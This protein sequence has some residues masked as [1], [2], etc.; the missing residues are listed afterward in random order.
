MKDTLKQFQKYTQGSGEDKKIQA[1]DQAYEHAMERV[2]GQKPG[3][4]QLAE[5]VLSWIT[6]AKR[7]LTTSELQHALAVEVGKPELDDEN[8]PQIESMVSVCVGLVTVDEESGII[9]LVHYTAQEYFKRTQKDWFPNVEES[10]TTS[11]VTYL[12]FSTF[13]GGVCSTDR[14]FEERL[15]SNQLYEYAAR[16]WGHH[17][18]QASKSSRLVIDFLESEGKVGA[19]SQALIADK[20]YFRYTYSQIFPRNMTGVHL[21]AYFGLEEAVNA[22][23]SSRRDPDLTD[24]HGRTPLSYAAENGHEAVVKLLLEKGAGVE[25]KDRYYGQTP[26]WRAAENGHEAVVELLLE[27]GADVES[28]DREFGR[29]PMLRAAEKGHE[30][31]VKLLLEKGADM[32][33]KDGGFGRTPLLRATEKGHEA[34]VKMLLEKGADMESTDRYGQTPLW[35]AAGKGHEAV[36]KLLLEKGAN[37]ESDDRKYGR[38]PLWWAS[39]NGHEAVVELLLEKGADVES[40]DTEYGQT[41]LWWAAEKGHEAV[42]KLLLEKGADVE[43]DDRKCGQTPLWWAS[44]NGHE[45]VVKLL[46]EKGADVESKDRYDGQTPLW[47]AAENG[48]EAVVKMLLEKGAEKLLH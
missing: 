40:K 41:P 2:Q 23:L 1:L 18:R 12:S 44:R 45:A 24:S 34:V 20:E 3:F 11:C 5:K 10:I 9:R 38:T 35:W 21:A 4:R 17:A 47:W 27:K 7:R 29:T 37:V 15:Q 43:S 36:V 33:S 25:S 6:C 48:H 14:E 13:D 19:S 28:K 31:V 46:L 39:R 22:V 8:F 16:N 32:E 42:V 30:A 26:L